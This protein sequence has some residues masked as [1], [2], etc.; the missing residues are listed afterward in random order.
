MT[1]LAKF[2][3][4]H[5]WRVFFGEVGVVVLGVLVALGAQQ[6]V[7]QM[8]TRRDVATFRTTINSEIAHNLW[9]YHYRDQG[10]ACTERRLAQLSA[11][12]DWL[13]DGSAAALADTRRPLNFSLYRSAWDNRDAA[14]FAALPDAARSKYAEFYDEL[15]NNESNRERERELWAGLAPFEVRGPVSLDDRRK[16]HGAMTAA[17]QLNSTIHNNLVVS[18]AIARRLGIAASQPDGM[19]PDELKAVHEC[20]PLV[21]EAVS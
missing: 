10:T 19:S 20:H 13:A 9:I 6:A 15:A 11:W 14:V 8:R 4:L 3:P 18:Y 16:L 7:E 21:A 1:R 17:H 2:S 5:G 12:V